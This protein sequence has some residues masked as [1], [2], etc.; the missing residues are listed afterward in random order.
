MQEQLASTVLTFLTKQI[1]TMRIC[2]KLIKAEVTSQSW[3]QRYTAFTFLSEIW[4]EWKNSLKSQADD[5]L[6]IIMN[7]VSEKYARIKYAGLMCLGLFIFHQTPI[8]Q[9][10]YHSEIIPQILEVIQN[11]PNDK[12][13]QI[14]VR[15]I[16]YF[17]LNF[18]VNTD[19]SDDID[20]LKANNIGILKH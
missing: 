9:K 15:V 2:M 12:I 4:P 1:E 13:K 17:I 8:I 10:K 3:K 7:G 6:E 19:D 11:N 14:A 18:N 5:I 20:E 16:K